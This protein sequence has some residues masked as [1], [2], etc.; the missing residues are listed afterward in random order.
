[1]PTPSYLLDHPLVADDWAE[2]LDRFGYG[3][4]LD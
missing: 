4:L 2:G 3:T 1:M